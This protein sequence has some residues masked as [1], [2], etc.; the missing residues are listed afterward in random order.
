MPRLT[1]TQV[2][3]ETGVHKSTVSRQANRL[4]LVGDDGL[5]D[6]EEYKA[7][8]AGGL[9]PALQTAGPAAASRQRSGGGDALAVARQRKMAAE[10]EEA[11]L[12]LRQRQGELIQRTLVAEVIGGALRK[13]RD[14]VISVPADLLTNLTDVNN[15]TEF[16]SA[17]FERAS[18][19]I[20]NHGGGSPAQ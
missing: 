9:D 20:L 5:V 8:R 18:V 16:I 19:E 15:C 12:N 2:A 17:A 1:I 13:L 14:E 10:A 6:L 11:E 3:I 7:A 4:G